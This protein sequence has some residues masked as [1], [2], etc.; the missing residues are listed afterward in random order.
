MMN[1]Q[2]TVDDAGTLIDLETLDFYDTVEEILPVLNEKNNRLNRIS[3]VISSYSF[4]SD[5]YR[6]N[7]SNNI[8][9]EDAYWEGIKTVC[10]IINAHL[11]DLQDGNLI[12]PDCG[13]ILV[14]TDDE[15]FD[16]MCSMCASYFTDEFIEFYNSLGEN[17]Q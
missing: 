11:N 15:D 12:C 1:D 8:Q 10:E 17:K 5:Q 2:F 9:V 13:G 4:L 6:H 14:P 16:Y 3:Q 7:I